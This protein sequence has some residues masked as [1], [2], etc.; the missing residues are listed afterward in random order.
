MHTAYAVLSVCV[1]IRMEVVLK[2]KGYRS[3]SRTLAH[4]QSVLRSKTMAVKL[5]S[6]GSSQRSNGENKK[7]RPCIEV[8]S[9]VGSPNRVSEYKTIINRFIEA[10]STKQGA[11]EQIYDL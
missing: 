8:F 2:R 11:T 1:G 5:V 10:K 9:F 4:S 6:I 3:S 7:R